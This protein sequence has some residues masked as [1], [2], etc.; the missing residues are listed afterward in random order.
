MKTLYVTPEVH[1][2]LCC[3]AAFHHRSL[4]DQLRYLL[5]ETPPPPDIFAHKFSDIQKQKAELLTLKP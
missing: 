5:T 2:Q 3:L 1:A 4:I